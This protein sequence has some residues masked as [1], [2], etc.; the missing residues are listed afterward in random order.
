[1]KK[2]GN[3]KNPSPIYETIKTLMERIAPL[4]IDSSAV[5]EL[6]SMVAK[7]LDGEGEEYDE[8]V[9]ETPTVR[10]LKLLQVCHCLLELY[11]NTKMAAVIGVLF[12]ST[13]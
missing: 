2:F 12:N 13:E 10:G 9:D 4:M 8:E 11:G 6:I 7:H 3:P 5:K 1:M